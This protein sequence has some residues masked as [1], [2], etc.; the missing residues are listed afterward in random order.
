MDEFEFIRLFSENLRYYL[1]LSNITQKELSEYI[2]V[3][4]STISRYLH[5][6]LMPT[7]KQVVNLAYALNCDVSDLIPCYELVQ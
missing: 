4:E 7:A 6:K 5:R 3:D 2:G 1:S